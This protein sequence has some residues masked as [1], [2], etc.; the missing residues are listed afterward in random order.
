MLIRDNKIFLIAIILCVCFSCENKKKDKN[1]ETTLFKVF[2]RKQ[3]TKNTYNLVYELANDSVKE[4]VNHNLKGYEY[5]RIN[6]WRIDSLICFNQKADKCVMAL[7][8]QSTF[9]KDQDADGITFLYGAK[10]M[11]KWYFFSG[12]FI[13]IPRKMYQKDIHTPL[14]FAKLH[15]I[16]MKEVFNGYLIEKK[17][18]KDLGWWKN[19]FSPEYEY[20]LNEDFFKQMESRNLDGT[21]GPFLKSFE[22]C[23]LWQVRKNWE[24]R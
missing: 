20:D 19:L 23:V 18:K 21:Y 12:A 9:Y 10:I 6:T 13:V 8:K 2:S 1:E 17:T 11:N 15:E 4:W 14:S 22:E 3:V 7:C 24:N 5:I 16:A